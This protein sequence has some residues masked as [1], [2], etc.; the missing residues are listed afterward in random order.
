MKKKKNRFSGILKGSLLVAG[1]LFLL[2][3]ILALTTL[4]FWAMY[5]LG[6]S[7]S[8]ITQ[9]PSTI[10]LLGGAGIP[11]GDG[12]L[13]TFYT[14]RLATAHP[15]AN[16]IIAM[17]GDLSDSTSAVRMAC[18]ELIL[19][20]V[21]PHSISYENKGRNT[22][23]QAQKLAAGK[24]ETQLKK[25]VVL[26]TI[27]E[28]MKRAVLTFRKCGFKTVGGLPA[29][30]YSLD[31]DLTFRDNDLK[32][33]KIAIPIGNNLQVRYQFWNHLK[34]E[35]AVIREYFGLLYYRLRGWI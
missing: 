14:A 11:S 16:V 35:V 13:R 33:N 22:R 32:G 15:E 31:A 26:V 8:R 7:N 10:I 3:C 20:G 18:K 5:S 17:P 23:E 6:T 24:S 34:Y 29:F 28:H 27:P 21:N 1:G 2:L 30:E 25:S 19:R 9:P 4:P 12:L